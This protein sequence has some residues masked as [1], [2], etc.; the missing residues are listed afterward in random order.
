[1]ATNACDCHVFAREWSK[2]GAYLGR[3][4]SCGEAEGGRVFAVKRATFVASRSRLEVSHVI[5]LLITLSL[6]LS[7]CVVVSVCA[8]CVS[9]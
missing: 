2:L 7:L 9:D 1:M 6:F 8:L 5:F 4:V 3:R